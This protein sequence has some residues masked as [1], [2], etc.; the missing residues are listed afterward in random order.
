MIVSW[1]AARPVDWAWAINGTR[2]VRAYTDRAY[3]WFKVHS[4]SIS[5]WR[6]A[7]DLQIKP[8]LRPLA[9][10]SGPRVEPTGLGGPSYA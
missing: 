10:T 8:V 9:E 4:I 1:R 6:A 3:L 7:V 5:P 2:Y